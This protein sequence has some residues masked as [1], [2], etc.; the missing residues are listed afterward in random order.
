LG[1]SIRILSANLKN[2]GADPEAFANLVT[3]LSIDVMAVQEV[4]FE[5]AEPL[6]RLFD[7]GEIVPDDHNVGRGLLCRHPVNISRFK[8]MWGFGQTVRLECA[9]WNQLGGPVEITN[10]HIAAPHMR[11]PRPGP[12][13]RWHQ[14]RELDAYLERSDRGASP[15]PARLLVGDFNATPAWP[16]Y[17]RMAKRFS[18]A[19][20]EFAAK[21]QAPTQPTWGP[22]P[23]GPKLLRIDH[24]FTRGLCVEGFEVLEVVGSDHSALVIDLATLATTE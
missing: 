24:G 7:Y 2:G 16:W 1:K 21:R 17:R 10:L 14:S 9:D 4:T 12:V 3:A 6:S 8:M 11:T 19:A 18:D 23:G 15:A 22:R 13:L 20:V 5:Q